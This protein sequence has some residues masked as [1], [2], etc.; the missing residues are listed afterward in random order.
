MNL[1]LNS[2]FPEGTTER[3][4]Y[5]LFLEL[6]S[7]MQEFEKEYAE[8]EIRKKYAD[9]GE[10]LSINQQLTLI[11]NEQHYYGHSCREILKQLNKLEKKILAHTDLLTEK[12]TEL[13]IKKAK[14]QT[15]AD[16]VVD[17]L[18]LIQSTADSPKN[19]SIE[20]S[21]KYGEYGWQWPFYHNFMEKLSEYISEPSQEKRE[22]LKQI[23]SNLTNSVLHSPTSNTQKIVL[24]SEEPEIRTLY[25]AEQYAEILE[26]NIGNLIQLLR[27]I[28]VMY[29]K[30]KPLCDIII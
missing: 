10:K 6:T 4:F 23:V 22:S 30:L 21:K 14:L 25:E 11:T 27:S 26:E 12:Y 24:Y 5:D 28:S 15:Y 1:N 3:K 18:K 29:Y 13:A 17:M 2:L 9:Y 19:I 16:I 20:M 8:A 7:K